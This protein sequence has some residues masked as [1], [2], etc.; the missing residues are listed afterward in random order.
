MEING[1]TMV[2]CLSNFGFPVAVAIYLLVRFEKKLD[3]LTKA[4][5]ELTVVVQR[6]GQ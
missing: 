5:H 3:Q 4:I 2:E 1:L 6:T